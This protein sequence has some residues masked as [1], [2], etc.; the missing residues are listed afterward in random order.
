MSLTLYTYWRSSAAYR[1]RIALG[2]KRMQVEQV[3]IHLVR[4]GG[5]QWAEGYR[6]RNPQGQVPLLEV[7]GAPLAQSL[8]IMEYLDEIQPEPPLLPAEPFA[9]AQA[10]AIAQAV[11]CDIHP[12]NNLKV[13]NY[14]RSELGADDDDIQAWYRTWVEKGL[15]AVEQLVLRARTSGPYCLGAQPML[16]D[17]CVVPQIFNA[18]RF[19]CDLSGCPALVEIDAAL[20]EHPAVKAA[21]PRNQ[22]DFDG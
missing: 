14:L 2:L 13:M 1:V 5:E 21:H 8:A 6:A 10:R 15:A 20:A 19:D 9:R 3:P 12:L 16:P 7:D 18:R 4:D 11:A 22:P 17:T